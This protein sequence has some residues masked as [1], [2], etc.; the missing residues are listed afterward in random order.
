[1]KS[2][3]LIGA[4]GVLGLT[5]GGPQRVRTY[6]IVPAESQLTILAAQEGLI[7]KLRPTHLI[8]VKAFAGRISLPPEDETKVAVEL[9][10]EAASLVNVDKEITDLERQEFQSILHDSVL[11]VARFPK[12]TFRSTGVTDVRPA[13]EGRR[14]TL[15][16]DLTLHGA[17]RRMAVPVTV[18]IA[19][20]QLRASGEA[21]LKQTA[22]D[23]KPYTGGFGAIK[24][25]DEVKVSF[26]I[27]ARPR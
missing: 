21:K 16:G 1:M 26:S 13:P 12:I 15:E 23:M 7:A 19:A 8:A 10:A 17:T 9:E 4:V 24:I 6:Q 20:G 5:A 14:F 27:L 22:F 25:G 18:A 11:E 2:L 3:L